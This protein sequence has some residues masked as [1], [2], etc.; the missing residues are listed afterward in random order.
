[1]T[2]HWMLGQTWLDIAQTPGGVVVGCP[3]CGT[4]QHFE[5]PEE[6]VLEHLDECPVA[7]LIADALRHFVE[8]GKQHVV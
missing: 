1:M 4:Q 6:P 8:G 3:G 5:P 7:C 2:Q